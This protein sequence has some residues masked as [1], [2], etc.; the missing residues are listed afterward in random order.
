MSDVR[1]CG[2]IHGIGLYN[3]RLWDFD[4]MTDEYAVM[5]YRTANYYYPTMSDCYEPTKEWTDEYDVSVVKWR[6][7]RYGDLVADHLS[8]SVR[9]SN[10]GKDVAN[11]VLWNMKNRKISFKEVVAEFE[12][13]KK[14]VR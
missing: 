9:L 5:F 13:M 8:D 3:E 4:V 14:G 2:M 1:R 6:K 11:Y 10:V 7:D 12:R